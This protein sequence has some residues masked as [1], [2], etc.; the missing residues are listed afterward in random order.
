MIYGATGYTG[1]L[2]A[3][4]AAR[5]GLDVVTYE[6]ENVPTA[7]ARAL[8]ECLPVYP[9]PDALRFAQDRLNGFFLAG[10]S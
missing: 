5:R 2:V 6:F 7:S 3:A 4:E 9:P 8:E 1:K 10:S